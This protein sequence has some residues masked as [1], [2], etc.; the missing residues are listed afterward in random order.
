M[1][2][3]VFL[4]AFISLLVITNPLGVASVFVG[5][6]SQATPAEVKATA[7]KS[8]WRR[9]WGSSFLGVC[10]EWLLTEL[11]IRIPLLFT[12]R[13]HSVVHDCFSHGVW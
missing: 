7:Y 6:M 4:N 10:G 5:P 9:V 2:M 12:S 11:G 8:R 3:Q 1:D 13:G